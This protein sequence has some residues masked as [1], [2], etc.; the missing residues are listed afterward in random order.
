LESLEYPICVVDKRAWLHEYLTTNV[1]HMYD[2]DTNNNNNNNNN[3]KK[4]KSD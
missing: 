2:D 3:N 4:K 1:L